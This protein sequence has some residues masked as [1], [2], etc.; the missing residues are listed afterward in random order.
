[1][2]LPILPVVLTALLSQ[3]AT[4]QSIADEVEAQNNAGAEGPSS[5]SS[6]G[7]SSE[8]MIIL[9]TIVGVVVF[10]GGMIYLLIFPAMF[11]S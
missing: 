7:V 3:T 4:A 1:M 5:E 10:I 9:C 11:S 2:Y 6:V 8:G